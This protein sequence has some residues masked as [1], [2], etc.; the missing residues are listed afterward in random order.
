M[1]TSSLKSIAGLLRT[2]SL[3]G[4]AMVL[5]LQRRISAKQIRSRASFSFLPGWVLVTN[6]GIAKDEAK[7]VW[8]T[9]HLE[10]VLPLDSNRL[11]LAAHSGG[12]W[13]ASLDEQSNSAPLSNSWPK[14]DIH[15]L[16]FGTKG[17]KHVYAAG[18]EGALFETET[19]SLASLT[20]FFST[21]S[22]K[23]LAARLNRKPPI[24]VRE[25]LG[26]S[27]A[28]IFDWKSI[29]LLDTNG[30]SMG[31]PAIYQVLSVTAFSPAKLV[32]ATSNGVFWSDIPAAGHEYRFAIADG[33]PQTRCL[34]LALASQSPG[35]DAHVVC[36][37]Q[38][39]PATRESNGIYFGTWL[40]GRLIMVR[41]NHVGDFDFVQ[42][43]DAVVA[44]SVGKRSVLYAAVSA[45]GRATLSLKRAFQEA[46]FSG[47][48]L[49]FSDLA[50][51][52]GIGRPA[53]MNAVIRK[54][55]PPADRDFIYAVVS[56]KDGGAT[57]F[58]VGPKHK[59]AESVDFPK[60]HDP[61]APGSTQ[62]GYNMS[63]AVSNASPDTIALGWRS[64]P[65][66]GR[67][68]PGAFAWEQHDDVST[69]HIHA[70]A[71]GMQF[72]PRDPQGRSLY[73]CSDGGIIFTTDLCATFKS[74]VNR[75]LPVLQ[76]QS[77]PGRQAPGASGVSFTTPRLVAGPLQDNGVV[78]SSL[79]NGIQ[80]P[81]QR[82]TVED[83]G[84]MGIFLKND[85]LLFWN[86][87]NP[88]ARVAKWTGTQ[89]GPEANVQVRTPSPRVP[90]GST[91]S[92]PF[93]EPVLRPAFRRSD[94][95]QLMVGIAA[96]D[97]SGPYRDLW[98]L[99]VD[100]DGNNAQW[101]FLATVSLDVDDSIKAAASD[102]GFGVLIGSAKGKIFSLDVSSGLLGAMRFDPLA[103]LPPGQIYQ[104]VFLTG[105]SAIARYLNGLLRF[106]PTS[107]NWTAIG[108]NGL[109]SNE[110][111]L[112]FMA[113]DTARV[114]NIL[115]VATDKG[116]HA[117][118]DVGENWLP[119]SQGLPLRS[120]PSTLR[121][122]TEPAGD[123]QLYLFTFGRSAWRARLN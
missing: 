88:V 71:H 116:I 32:L 43:N 48:L 84:E 79:Q 38:G 41:A 64:G 19:Q 3:K 105:G 55:A 24:S 16:G 89:F 101:D 40:F 54:I 98:G 29:S 51:K 112:Y 11:L 73:M 80:K 67:N 66:I 115:Y 13:L 33:I 109:P 104:F 83:D 47:A 27:D 10:D 121:F 17:P 69:P 81:W 93:A 49:K 113:V 77:Y 28:P 118:W 12:V 35:S 78:F 21:K 31:S 96:Y 44:S 23:E 52:V 56:S 42:W 123:R 36:S 117:S 99:F 106:E 34:G 92:Q 22:V 74:S 122:V 7:N 68:K 39:S 46:G 111:P 63:I 75:F 72:D 102:D 25:L 30:N 58:P 9:G 59:V 103:S 110:G 14:V 1:P 120:H 57:W 95:N 45:S 87:D 114:P 8:H 37:P 85:L 90:T 76:F 2:G 107:Q 119:V 4:M 94:T 61:K 62:G 97:A 6:N 26:L 50:Q 5:G 20:R 82:I 60:D 53:S 108:G 100:D 70:D 91:F 65:W 18:E 15:C 86:N